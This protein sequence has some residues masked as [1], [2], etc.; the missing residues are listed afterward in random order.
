MLGPG[1]SKARGVN[2]RPLWRL[3]SG[4]KDEKM[5]NLTNTINLAANCEKCKEESDYEVE[6]SL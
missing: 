6:S 3:W 1:R 5:H 4:D 2:K